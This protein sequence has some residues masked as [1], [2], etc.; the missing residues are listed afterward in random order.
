MNV[1]KAGNENENIMETTPLNEE[2]IQEAIRNGVGLKVDHEVELRED[3]Q[4]CMAAREPGTHRQPCSLGNRGD[5]EKLDESRRGRCNADEISRCAFCQSMLEDS[6][7]PRG[8]LNGGGTL[9]LLASKSVARVLDSDARVVTPENSTR[10]LRNWR[11][12]QR[13]F[14]SF[15]S[16]GGRRRLD[17]SDTTHEPV[18]IG[19]TVRCDRGGRCPRRKNEK[20]KK[21][22]HRL[23]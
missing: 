22:R 23:R 10:R 6:S 11:N 3:P 5:G 2:Q 21:L 20:K 14:V 16:T 7:D 13:R 1:E 18:R 4:E 9:W 17:V 19:D 12:E 15:R 8:Q